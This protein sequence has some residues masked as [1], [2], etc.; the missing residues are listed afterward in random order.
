VVAVT[1][2]L[3]EVVGVELEYAIVDRE[4]LAVRP[5]ADELLAE[6]AGEPSDVE[7][8]PIAWSNELVLHVIEL[9]TNG[10]V[11]SLRAAAPDFAEAVL[12]IDAL[13]EPLGA[14]L[15]PGAMHPLMR[16]KR[17]TRLW[18]HEGR[19][20]YETYDRIF[21]TRCHGFANVQSMH[22]N[23]PFRGDAELARL[24]AAVRVVLPLLPA[25]AASSPVCEGAVTGLLDTRLEHY[26]TNQARVPSVAG[27]VVPEAI[28]S[29]AEYETRILEPMWRDIAPHDPDLVLR[30]EFLN[31]RGAIVRFDRDA[32]E[33]RLIDMQ[34][35][36]RLDLAL[37]RVV[38]GAV[39]ALV[40]E[41]WTRADALAVPTETLARLLWAAV[42]TGP[43]TP[44][45]DADVARAFG[46]TAGTTMEAL[47]QQVGDA[48]LPADD[49]EARDWLALV[50]RR[51]TLAERLLWRLGPQP[52][53]DHI[54]ETYGE[55]A[56][57]L[58]DDRPFV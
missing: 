2:G 30:S 33:I 41:R 29:R 27:A 53:R 6:V 17:E 56:R 9:K 4:T 7:D 28:S 58:V 45:D 10:P 34:E 25:L 14:M 42:R 48:V 3:F 37:A 52:S 18:P 26:R 40:E 1:W 38:T 15:L 55:L 23:L 57:C 39:R 31:S 51:G 22:V 8:G 5:I 12:R 35:A 24:H 46:V 32:V 50:A 47:W 19:E 54:V 43:A 13:L 16:P 44:V 49:A 11:A 21:G 36:P 20:I